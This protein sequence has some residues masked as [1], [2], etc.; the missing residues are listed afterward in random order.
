MVQYGC[1]EPIDEGLA[2]APGRVSWF[3][4]KGVYEPFAA[5]N[6]RTE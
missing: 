5:D 1:S 2:E 3:F 4:C 6:W